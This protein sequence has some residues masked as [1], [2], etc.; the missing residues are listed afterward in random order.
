MYLTTWKMSTWFSFSW[1]DDIF[2]QLSVDEFHSCGL[3]RDGSFVCWGKGHVARSYDGEFS[4]IS[5]GPFHVCALRADNGSVQC[6]GAGFNDLTD[7]PPGKFVQVSAGGSQTCAIRPNGRVECWGRSHKVRLRVASLSPR[8]FRCVS[9]RSFLCGSFLFQGSLDVPDEQFVQVSV[10]RDGT[11]CGVTLE[12]GVLCW[13]PWT[14]TSPLYERPGG[15]FV[16]VS[17]GDRSMCAMRVR[18]RRKGVSF[19]LQEFVETLA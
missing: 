9:E 1:Q 17:V 16:Q 11:T 4:A 18:C 13:G 12:G 6:W 5:T 3:R 19:S 14:G 2:T 8:L 15:P 10:G 7:P